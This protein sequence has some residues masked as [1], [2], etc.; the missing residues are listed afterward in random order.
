MCKL[1][2][3]SHVWWGLDSEP[4]CRNGICAFVLYITLSSK[5]HVT[6]KELLCASFSKIPFHETLVNVVI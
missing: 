4:T 2:D 1:H 5:T 3:I 6:F